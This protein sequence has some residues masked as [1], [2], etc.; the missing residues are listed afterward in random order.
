MKL[1][2]NAQLWLLPYI[3]D[4]VRRVKD[5]VRPRRIWITIADHYEPV[6]NSKSTREALDCVRHWQDR[7]YRIAADAPRDGAGR[8]PRYCFFYPEEE[9][10][11]ELLDG[12]SE[13][14]HAGIADVEIHIHHDRETEE[15]FLRKMNRF[16][17]CLFHD[18]GLLREH[19]GRI[20]F[21]FIHGNW[22]LDNSRPDGRWCGLPGEVALLRDLGCYADFTMPSLPSATQGRVVNQIYWCSSDGKTSRCFDRGIEAAMGGGVQ[23]D[24]LMITGPLGIRFRERL[25]P[26]LETGEVAIYDPPTPYRVRRWFDLAPRI[27]EDVF[28]KLYTHGAQ[29]NNRSMLL[30]GGLPDLLGWC[31]AEAA[32]RQMELRWAT[33]WEMFLAVDGLVQRRAPGYSADELRVMRTSSKVV[34]QGTAP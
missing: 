28:L 3:H 14:V 24:L 6:G 1:P 2:R 5:P 31:A 15:A 13:L 29:P 30:G 32:A 25:V 23:G 8:S 10:R 12:L 27:G 16:T 20:R 19:D 18:H 4:R 34:S 7:W 22:A 9:Y 26:R 21:G 33:A 17:Q 11:R